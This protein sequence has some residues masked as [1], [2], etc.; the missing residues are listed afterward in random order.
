MVLAK[1]I[2]PSPPPPTFTPESIIDLSSKVNI[3]TNCTTPTNTSLAAILYKLHATVYIGTPSVSVYNGVASQLRKECP[4]S[5]GHLKPFIYN[6][7]DLQSIKQAVRSFL[8]AEWRLDILFLDALE[9]VDGNSM[10]AFLLAK[11]LSAIMHTTA[12]HFCHPNPSIRVIWI[13]NSSIAPVCEGNSAGTMY[14]LAHEFAHR[15]YSHVNDPHIHILS[16]HNP[17]GVQHVVVV[18]DQ[19]ASGP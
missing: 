7:A 6:V 17:L 4:E 16:N 12:T 14:M 5:K 3:V 9:S 19:V 8:E 18:V 2:Q 13:S 11:L 10:P 1:S 15:G